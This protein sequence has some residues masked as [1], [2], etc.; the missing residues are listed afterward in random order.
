MTGPFPRMAVI[1]V[2]SALG[3]FHKLFSGLIIA[4]GRTL[5]S[6]LHHRPPRITGE[7][8]GGEYRLRVRLA[9][10]LNHVGRS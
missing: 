1:L 3:P 7:R 2:A 10:P 4:C 6:R 5:A 8:A 9:D